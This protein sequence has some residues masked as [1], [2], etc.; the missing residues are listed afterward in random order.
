[1]I[2]PMIKYTFLLHHAERERLLEELG[3]TAIVDITVASWKADDSDKAILSDMSRAHQATEKLKGYIAVNKSKDASE[4]DAEVSE[5]DSISVKNKVGGGDLV[6]S[7]EV[8][9]AR[10][11]QLVPMLQK[12]R[13]E[14][15]WLES[16]G[17]FDVKLIDKLAE[18]GLCFHYFSTTKSGFKSSWEADYNLTI[19]S[20]EGSKQV[21]FV[22]VSDSDKPFDLDGARKE[23]QLTESVTDKSLE[24]AQFEAELSDIQSSVLALESSIPTLEAYQVDLKEALSERKVIQTNV[25]AAEGQIVVIEG[26]TPID[27][28]DEVDGLFE[29][30]NS[31]VVVKER[32]IE[33]DNPP[34][35]LKNNKFARV[36]EVIT[37]LYSMP[38]YT[39]Q[40]LTPFFAPF[41]IFFVGV[42]MGDM[43]YGLLLFVPALIAYFKFKDTDSKTVASLVMWCC[44]ATVIMGGV[45]GT[46]FGLTLADYEVFSGVPFLG[47]MDMFSFSLVV[48]VIQILYAMIVKGAFEV[49]S[50]GFKWGISTFSWAAAIITSCVAFMGEDMGIAFS[51]SS[52]I[53]KGLIALFIVLYILFIDPSKKNVFTNLGG[54]L[55]ALYNALTGI[56]GD[57]LSYIR[58]FALGLS[59]GIIAGVFNDLAIA[60]SG[61]IPV[62]KYIIMILILLIGHSI[63]IFMSAI[64]SFVHPLRLTFV[65][66]YK[67]AGFEGGGRNYQPFKMSRKAIK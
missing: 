42:C 1:M 7:F 25:V 47:Q 19:C 4:G 36:G 14:Q 5:K 10:I 35:L 20:S 18:N 44:L 6:S 64:S 41:F 32:F 52:P 49:R 54:G 21:N 22:I 26:W 51:M 58:L 28:C 40:D 37:R 62:V 17:E 66:F 13:K 65:E 30:N 15:E 8:Y 23:K 34:I 45:T 38:Q 3:R 50:K 56:L 2:T 33:G 39:E 61:D 12:L 46:F 57:T 53:Y 43:G 60:M 24:L 63:N 16:W 67:C 9:M 31:V 27:K 55:W 29:A 59:S 48:G 11:E